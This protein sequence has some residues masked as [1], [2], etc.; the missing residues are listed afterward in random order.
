[1]DVNGLSTL[2]QDRY[3]VR[4]ESVPEQRFAGMGPVAS[5]DNP[6]ISITLAGEVADLG[7]TEE[8]PTADGVCL[9]VSVAGRDRATAERVAPPTGE[10]DAWLLAFLGPEWFRHAYRAGT[11][12]GGNG[13]LTTVYYRL[14]LDTEGNPI[15]KPEDY[16]D[17]DLRRMDEL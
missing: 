15:P 16:E 13:R 5:L 10:T 7:W 8:D 11:R 17:A 3:R 6:G 14:F 1:M 4:G 12:S 9:T 2:I